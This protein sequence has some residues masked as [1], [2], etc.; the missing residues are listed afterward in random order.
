MLST[1]IAIHPLMY[2]WDGWTICINGVILIILT[3]KVS[4]KIYHI[5]HRALKGIW[6]P[7][8]TPAKPPPKEWVIR[9]VGFWPPWL[10]HESSSLLR[11]VLASVSIPEMCHWLIEESAS[12]PHDLC[13]WD[14]LPRSTRGDLLASS[15]QLGTRV[16]TS[17]MCGY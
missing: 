5:N 7:S 17:S 16:E 13:P 8:I 15:E 1:T 14:S 9:L 2:Q 4:K 10:E 3:M 6:T 11:L 12:L